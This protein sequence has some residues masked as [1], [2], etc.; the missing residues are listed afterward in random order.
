MR[1]KISRRVGSPN[2]PVTAATT[3]AN[4]ASAICA[5]S[6]P[7][8]WSG[9]GDSSI[10]PDRTPVVYLWAGFSNEARAS[11]AHDLAP[12]S[13]AASA[14]GRH[15]ATDTSGLEAV[16]RAV[17]DPVTGLPLQE[18]RMLVALGARR[19]RAEVDVA[20]PVQDW[21]GLDELR[22]ALEEAARGIGFKE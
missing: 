22:A 3:E 9:A 7:T 19:H 6:S 16:L 10:E 4:R 13:R 8:P 12:S 17:V 1:R 14:E 11:G 20:L 21:P 2:A 15:M 18:T 5:P